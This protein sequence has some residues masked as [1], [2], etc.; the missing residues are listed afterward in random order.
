MSESTLFD[1][2]SSVSQS[3]GPRAVC[4]TLIANLKASEQHHQVFDARMLARKFELGLPLSRPSSLADVP[5]ARRKELEET[6]VSAA[7]EAG[8]AFLAANDIPAAWM[9]YQVI[10]EPEPVAA[11]LDK[12]PDGP[13]SQQ[14][15]ELMQIALYQAVHPEKGVRMMIKNHG[16]CSTI[17]AL[18]QANQ[19]I[20]PAQRQA[21]ARV[22]VCHLYEELSANVRRPV[23]ERLPMLDG[24]LSLRELIGGRE[25][26]FEGGNYHVDVSHLNAV[27]RFARVLESN[28]PELEFALQLAEYGSRLDGP[29][30]YG[31]DAPFDEF[32]LAHQ[33]FFR[34]LLNKKRDEG[35]QYFCDRLAAE[36]DE[37]DQPMLAYVLVDLLARVEKLDDAVQLAREYLTDVGEEVRF[38][39]AELCR[40]AKKLEILQQVSRERNDPVTFAAALLPTNG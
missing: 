7:R 25:W 23:Q 21:C 30:Q 17:T 27:V 4:E 9:Y 33:H 22:M 13:A 26:L 35:L 15:E 40:E 5:P 28:G 37:R 34:V 3:G 32:Y 2:L 19:Q 16:T 24:N 29:L 11:A 8:E 38:S 10:R 39:F 14:T 18:E 36:P 20:S 1:E 6:Y 12:I 31:G